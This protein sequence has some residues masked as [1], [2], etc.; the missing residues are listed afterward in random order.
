MTQLLRSSAGLLWCGRGPAEGPGARWRALALGFEGV[1]VAGIG[2]SH[3]PGT[4]ERWEDRRREE[5]L[6]GVSGRSR[7]PTWP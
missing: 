3:P 1:F 2:G 6:D 4:R 7:V 5:E